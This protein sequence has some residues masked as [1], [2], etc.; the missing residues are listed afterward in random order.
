M[1][2]C[3]CI[4]L[5]DDHGNGFTAIA[6]FG[7]G[8]NRLICKL[9]YDTMQVHT[10]N[11]ARRH[12]RNDAGMTGHES[13]NVAKLKRCT[14]MRRADDLHHQRACRDGVCAKFLLPV[15]LRYSVDPAQCLANRTFARINRQNTVRPGGEQHRINNFCIA[16][17][18]AQH[19]AQRIFDGRAVRCGR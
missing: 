17:A 7:F 15:D 16:G 2:V 13:V 8:K 9:R 3:D 14:M 6:G 19:T 12:N 5:T 10:G 18:P 11:I 4:L 1:Q